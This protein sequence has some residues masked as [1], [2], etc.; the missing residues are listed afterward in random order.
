M[1]VCTF[2]M[3]GCDIN[4]CNRFGNIRLIVDVLLNLLLSSEY[5]KII[6]GGILIIFMNTSV[7][8]GSARSRYD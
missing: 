4:A 1:V 2:K 8:H 7:C 5:W 6:I 3:S